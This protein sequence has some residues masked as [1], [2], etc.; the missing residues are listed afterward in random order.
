RLDR[1][2]RRVQK[3]DNVGHSRWGMALARMA[4]LAWTQGCDDST[5][6]TQQ[7]GE[8]C[9]SEANCVSGLFCVD[10][11]C[12]DA[13]G[14]YDMSGDAPNDGSTDG[15]DGDDDSLGGDGGDSGDGTG[16]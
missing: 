11:I 13:D 3:G 10:N 15:T 1:F 14:F 9:G 7:I 8:S 6:G 5:S 16:G 4:M 2:R 12:V